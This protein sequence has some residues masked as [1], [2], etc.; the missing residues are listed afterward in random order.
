LNNDLNNLFNSVQLPIVML[1]RDLRIRRYTPVS[2][3]PFNLIPS[4]VGRPITDINMN[5]AIPKLEEWLL[6]V[7]DKVSIRE[8]DI[9]D[10]S[11]HWYKLQLRPY[12]TID[13]KIDGAVLTLLDI[14]TSKR[15]QQNRQTSSESIQ[16]ILES[17]REPTLILDKDLRVHMAN[18]SFSKR[19]GLSKEQVKNQPIW[20][21]DGKRWNIKELH[22]VLDG[23]LHDGHEYD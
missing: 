15:D 2:E 9:Q 4:D 18:D 20:E 5:I 1:G 23:I 3:K 12:K 10:R 22:S 16:S 19:F 14:E 7:I 13:N 6:E 17:I 11:G 21:L 8:E